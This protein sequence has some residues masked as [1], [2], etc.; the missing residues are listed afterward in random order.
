[1]FTLLRRATGFSLRDELGAILVP[2]MASGA[3]A[4][5]VLG[6]RRALPLE[7]TPLARLACLVPAGTLTFLLGMYSFGRGSLQRAVDFAASARGAKA[8]GG[9]HAG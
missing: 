2:L 3:M 8:A 7:L 9:E 1:M 6:L 4:L 5:V